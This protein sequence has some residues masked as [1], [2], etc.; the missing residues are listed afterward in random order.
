MH[1]GSR[2]ISGILDMYSFQPVLSRISASL[3]D[4]GLGKRMQKTPRHLQKVDAC[5]NESVPKNHVPNLDFSQQRKYDSREHI[6]KAQ[7]MRCLG[8]PVFLSVDGNSLGK[9]DGI[10]NDLVVIRRGSLNP[11]WYYFRHVDLRQLKPN[12]QKVRDEQDYYFGRSLFLDMSLDEASLFASKL[13]PDPNVYATLGVS[14]DI[15]DA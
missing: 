4:S 3:R 8:T 1:A 7:W 15:D 10:K 14:H 2:I 5:D 11:T 9:I 6:P 13:P 12:P